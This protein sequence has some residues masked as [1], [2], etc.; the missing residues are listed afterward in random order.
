MPSSTAPQVISE[1]SVM[2]SRTREPRI[3]VAHESVAEAGSNGMKGTGTSI[4]E[5]D[6]TVAECAACI[7]V[8]VAR[9]ILSQFSF[10]SLCTHRAVE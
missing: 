1:E 5:L 7:L 3:S 8:N 10:S 4:S 9:S 6:S 2:G